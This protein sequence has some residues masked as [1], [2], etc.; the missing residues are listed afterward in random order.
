MALVG[1]RK[2]THRKRRLGRTLRVETLELRVMLS[3]NP[4]DVKLECVASLLAFDAQAAEY[5]DLSV[6]EQGQTEGTITQVVVRAGMLDP[7][8]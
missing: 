5:D 6:V 4:L 3:S 2:S 7:N 1:R 8:L